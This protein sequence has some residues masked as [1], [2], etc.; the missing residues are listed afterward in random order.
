M[1]SL[2]FRLDKLLCRV[3][4]DGCFL[5]PRAVACDP[6]G[7][8]LLAD[9]GNHRIQR[10]N[11]CG[12]LKSTFGS[13]GQGPGEFQDPCSLAV[14]GSGEI[15]VAERKNHRIQ[16]FSNQDQFQDDFKTVDPPVYVAR[17]YAGTIV[18]STATGHIE[19]YH[20]PGKLWTRFRLHGNSKRHSSAGP[21]TVNNKDEVV[22]FNPATNRIQY[23]SYSGDLLYE[24]EPQ[25]VR[26]RLVCH[27]SGLCVTAAG[28]L[29]V[30]DCLNHTVNLYSERGRLEEQVLGPQDDLGQARALALGPEGHLVVTEYTGKGE[31]CFKIFRYRQCK[32][33]KP[34]QKLV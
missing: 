11:Q 32:C 33:H 7:D 14:S 34:R 4:G 22:V 5:Y 29:L 8:V 31:H 30:T 17:D 2:T 26:D 25:G 10:F 9:T 1:T 20:R 15:F 21:I 27:P 12:V 16:I 6:D 24:F 3:G 19:T 18:V 23:Y 13:P 28:Q